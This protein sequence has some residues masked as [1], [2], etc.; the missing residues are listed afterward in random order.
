MKSMARGAPIYRGF[1]PRSCATRIRFR[2]YLQSKFEPG[3]GWHLVDFRLAEEKSCSVKSSRGRRVRHGLMLA[4]GPQKRMGKEV[5][6]VSWEGRRKRAGRSVRLGR[7]SWAARVEERDRLGGL[8]KKKE[9]GWVLSPR[10]F[11]FK[12]NI[13]YFSFNSWFESNSNSIRI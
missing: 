11:G 6:W 7:G 9:A 12:Q 3:F 10:E 8:G 13:F 2:R 1:A 4:T 5:R